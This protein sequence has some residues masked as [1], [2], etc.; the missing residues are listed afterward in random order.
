M[1]APF[2][3]AGPAPAAPGSATTQ[4]GPAERVRPS[5]ARTSIRPDYVVGSMRGSV[6]EVIRCLARGGCAAMPVFGRSI[7][8]I[9]IAWSTFAACAGRCATSNAASRCATSARRAGH[10]QLALAGAQLARRGDERAERGVGDLGRPR[11]VD[12][13]PAH[14]RRRARRRSAARAPRASRRSSVPRTS[15]WCTTSSSR[16]S[17]TASAPGLTTA[18]SYCDVNMAAPTEYASSRVGAK[19]AHLGRPHELP[20]RARDAAR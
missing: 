15:S 9:M 11:E 5:S 4:R 3:P 17:R 14:A 13:Q 6:S 10:D 20:A 1:V 19:H 12:D 16:C 8:R 2:V 18:R 7:F